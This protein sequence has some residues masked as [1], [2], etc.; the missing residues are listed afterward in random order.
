[1][2]I[3]I[4]ECNRE[5]MSRIKYFRQFAEDQQKE[6]QRKVEKRFKGKYTRSLFKANADFVLYPWEHECYNN[7]YVFIAYEYA[8]P[9]PILLGWMLVH[10]REFSKLRYGPLTIAHVDYISTNQNIGKGVGKMMMTVMK[11]KMKRLN[12]DLI[13]LMPLPLVV[14][15]YTKL[16]YVLEFKKVNYYTKWLK[17][18]PA[19]RLIE[20][21]EHQL[22]IEDEKIKIKI[23]EEEAA[24]FQPI[25]EQ[26]TQEEQKIYRAMQKDDDSTRIG[27]IFTYEEAEEI[28]PGTGIIE[29]RKMV[30]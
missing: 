9:R 5:N 14:G 15:F 7:G 29:V 10:I 4:L 1:M 3:E 21:Y 8:K 22:N 27:M 11:N 30:S 2:N 19:E 24:N 16:G 17:P 6:S 18:R 26:F 13:E 28:E 12:C 23:E 20:M 25:Y